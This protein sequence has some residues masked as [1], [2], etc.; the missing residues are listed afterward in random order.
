[1]SLAGGRRRFAR[2]GPGLVNAAS[3]YQ[4]RRMSPTSLPWMRTRSGPNMRVS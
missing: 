2:D 4:Y 3:R 1:M